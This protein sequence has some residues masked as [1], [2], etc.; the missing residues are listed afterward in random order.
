MSRSRAH[1]SLST[2]MAEHFK[3]KGVDV[4]DILAGSNAHV[5]WLARLER[6]LENVEKFYET[7]TADYAAQLD[8]M[9]HQTKDRSVRAV[10]CGAVQG[11]VQLFNRHHCRCWG[12]CQ[13]RS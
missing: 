13:R 8:M 10:Q 5:R 1:H 7:Q 3:A 12:N 9:C 2:A 11:F 6:Q 4:S